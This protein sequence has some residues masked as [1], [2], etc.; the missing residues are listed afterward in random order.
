MYA[1]GGITA[2]NKSQ[3]H[4]IRKGFSFTGMSGLK[5]AEL[6]RQLAKEMPTVLDSL[7][8]QGCTNAGGANPV[9]G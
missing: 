9:A 5:D 2:V 7:A 4:E 6:A 1:R 3:S 8:H